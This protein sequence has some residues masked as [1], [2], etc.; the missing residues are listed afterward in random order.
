MILERVVLGCNGMAKVDA[1]E[2]EMRG[3]WCQGLYW[4]QLLGFQVTDTTQSSLSCKGD[5]SVHV[6]KMSGARRAR[7]RAGGQRS[8][9][10]MD[11]D[12]VRGV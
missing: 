12:E 7:Q 1:G 4:S 5:L 3:V 9:I 2:M 6:T 8:T 11:D 10:S